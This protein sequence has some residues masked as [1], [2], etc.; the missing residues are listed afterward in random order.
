LPRFSFCIMRLSNH[1]CRTEIVHLSQI[2]QFII[3]LL[4]SYDRTFHSI[5]VAGS[6]LTRVSATS[7]YMSARI[8]TKLR[9]SGSSVC[10]N[11]LMYIIL[12]CFSLVIRISFLRSSEFS[13]VRSFPCMDIS[14]I[15]LSIINLISSGKNSIVL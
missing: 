13:S 8:S 3:W 5:W 4:V 1:P 12:Y 9:Q 10:S 15:F 11:Y 7:G 6:T 2:I 14:T